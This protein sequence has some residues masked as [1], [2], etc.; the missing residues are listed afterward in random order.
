MQRKFQQSKV[1]LFIDRL[2]VSVVSE[3]GTHSAFSKTVKTPLVQFLDRLL[4]PVV[5]RQVH[6]PDSTEDSGVAAGAAPAEL[7]T[8]LVEEIVKVH[9]F[10]ELEQIVASRA[11]DHGRNRRSVSACAMRSRSWRL[12]P[13]IME[14]IV[15]EFS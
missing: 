15:E 9:S 11:T 2:V 6:G 10:Y 14:E 3:T 8:L 7:W 1:F 13:Q 5:P 12:V 4:T